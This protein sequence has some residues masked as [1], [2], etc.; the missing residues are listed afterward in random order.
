[1]TDIYCGN[2]AQD[3]QLLSGNK[4]LGTRYKCMRRGVGRGIHLPYDPK[5]GGPYVPLDNRKIY[6]GDRDILPN[7]YDRFGNLPQCL[8]KGVGIGKSI[9]AKKGPPKWR[10][11]TPFMLF[12][13]LETALFTWLYFKPPSFIRKNE[14]K[15]K[16]TVDWNKFITF[17]I[18]V[19]LSLGIII[20]LIFRRR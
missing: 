17:F 2:N 9:R 10:I 1:M 13:L 5:F 18:P 7:D 20:Y 16:V 15:D 12:L 6:C 3:V 8:Q 11:L 14:D 4:V 19:T